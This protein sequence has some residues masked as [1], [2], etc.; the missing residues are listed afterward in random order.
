MPKE[1]QFDAS[2]S[3]E[4]KYSTIAPQIEALLSGE[5]DVVANMANICAAL[6]SAFDFFWVG[7]YIVKNDE[8]V[9]GPFQ[10][11]V[12]CS[13]IQFGKGVCGAVCESGKTLIVPNVEEFSGHIACNSASRSEI[14]IPLFRDG[15][16]FGVLDV[17]SDRLDAFDDVDAKWLEKIT[18]L[19]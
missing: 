2:M 10:G 14:V 1:L 9:L 19:F 4:E 11:P 17:D 3:R 5:S 16:L 8:L 15:Q 6:K 13:R 7:F 18:Q 12:G